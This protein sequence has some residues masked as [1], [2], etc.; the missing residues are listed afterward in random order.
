MGTVLNE[1]IITVKPPS[2]K[3]ASSG[4]GS[5]SNDEDYA[6]PPIFRGPPTDEL[7]EELPVIMGIMVIVVVFLLIV[8]L[9]FCYK[10]KTEQWTCGE[11]G[12]WTTIPANDK[13]SQSFYQYPDQSNYSGV[14]RATTKVCSNCHSSYEIGKNLAYIKQNR[15]VI[16]VTLSKDTLYYYI[17]Q[18]LLKNTFFFPYSCNCPIQSHLDIIFGQDCQ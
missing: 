11:N 10:S 14:S 12:Q 2:G 16:M 6:A 7:P 1:H 3:S 4:Q 15:A 5:S 18:K 9:T 13:R 17:L 8:M